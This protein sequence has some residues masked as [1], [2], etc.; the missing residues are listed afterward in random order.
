MA[1]FDLVAL[2][3]GVACSHNSAHEIFT[4][5]I[6]KQCKY[7][8]YPCTSGKDF[9]KG[10]CLKCGSKGCNS[11]GYWASPDRDTDKLYLNT[12]SVLEKPFCLENYKFALVSAESK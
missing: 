4:D 8:S 11:L 3:K 12:Q 1:N 9:D 2:E 6:A 7:T 5:S 10:L